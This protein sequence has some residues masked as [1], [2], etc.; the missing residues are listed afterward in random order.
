MFPLPR[1]HSSLKNIVSQ[2]IT[3]V[4]GDASVTMPALH[5]SVDSCARHLGFADAFSV[6]LPFLTDYFTDPS[7]LPMWGALGNP[8]LELLCFN[9]SVHDYAMLSADAL[10]ALIE[11]HG[12]A[13]SSEDELLEL[14]LSLGPNFAPLF[15][16]VK[17]DFVSAP[18]LATFMN[19]VGF[20]HAH[21]SVWAGAASRLIDHG[22]P[23]PV[24]DS[25]ILQKFPP[26]FQ[27]F[28][29]GKFTLLWRGSR[30]GFASGDYHKRCNGHANLLTV[31][32]D[33]NGN[34]FGGYSPIKS[35]TTQNC[36][37]IPDMQSK[38]FIFTLVNP[39]GVPPRKFV[40]RDRSCAVT[41]RSSRGPAF[42]RGDLFLG[43][44]CSTNIHKN[45]AALGNAYANDTGLDGRTLLT[46][47]KAFRVKEVEVFEIC[48]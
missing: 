31:V 11:R 22:P 40:L 48:K 30:D 6:D 10:I 25:L 4:I 39:N 43:G 33:E 15:A 16:F 46:G 19:A 47:T 32:R 42:G 36:Q 34:V 7:V 23:P 20:A 35:Q 1:T 45:T 37:W 24:I 3:L 17:F 27:E 44:N 18:G 2:P 41:F 29:F 8:E 38:S 21:D 14:I 5:L 9:P 28:R 13:M 12:A 26:H